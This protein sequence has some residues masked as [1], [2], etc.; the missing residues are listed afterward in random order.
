MSG[1][2]TYSF[3]YWSRVPCRFNNVTTVTEKSKILLTYEVFPSLTLLVTAKT[4]EGTEKHSE[5]TAASGDKKSKGPTIVIE[6]FEPFPPSFYK[7]KS[8]SIE[9][10]LTCLFKLTLDSR[11]PLD[12][13]VGVLTPK[14]FKW[15][16]AWFSGSQNG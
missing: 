1:K 16:T 2:L 5:T 14:I 3:G 4:S 15:P 8:F 13:G 12:M 7:S 6:K 9:F 11:V 10:V